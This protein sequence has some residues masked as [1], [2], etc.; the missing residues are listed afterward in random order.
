M[1]ANNIKV[2]N[3]TSLIMIAKNIDGNVK[4]VLDWRAALALGAAFGGVLGLI[5]ILT[6]K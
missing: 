2:E 5:K 1:V 4:T 3:T 6:K